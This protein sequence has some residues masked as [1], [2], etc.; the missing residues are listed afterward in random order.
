MPVV[1]RT[2]RIGAAPQA[3]RVVPVEVARLAAETAAEPD[4]RRDVAP[5]PLPRHPQVE[6]GHRQHEEGGVAR[7]G[8]G[9]RRGPSFSF[10]GEPPVP[11]GDRTVEARGPAANRYRARVRCRDRRRAFPVCRRRPRRPRADPNPASR[12]W[13][14]RR[15]P[16]AAPAPAARRRRAGPPRARRRHDALIAFDESQHGLLERQQGAGH[17]HHENHRACDDAGDQMCPEEDLAECHD[18]CSELRPLPEKVVVDAGQLHCRRMIR[19]VARPAAGSP[20][21]CRTAAC[22]ARRREPGSGSRRTRR[23]ARPA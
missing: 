13:A 12:W 10:H 7:A 6:T 8:D 5:A 16:R 9:A 15:E 17:A 23:C 4:H 1:V 2:M 20:S 11:V 21:P 3:D 18:C 19:C 22:A 14:R